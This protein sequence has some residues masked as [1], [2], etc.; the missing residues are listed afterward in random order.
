MGYY[1][2]IIRG[3]IESR[4]AIVNC[5]SDLGCLG[6][7]ERQ[8]DLVAYFVDSRD[9]NLIRQRL[10]L[11][12]DQLRDAGLDNRFSFDYSYLS[13]RDWNEP[14]KKRFV[15]IEIGDR[16]RII[17][18][19]GK[20]SPDRLDIIIDPGMAFGTGH[21]ETTLDCL[22]LIE[23]YSDSVSK[24]RFLDIGTGTGILAI[25]ASRFG[26]G[27]VLG[28]DIDPLAI[29]AA[30]RNVRLNRIRNIRIKEGI[31]RDIQGTFDMIAANL[32]SDVL[33]SISGEMARLLKR[34]GLIILSGMLEGQEIEVIGE[35]ERFG[36]RLIELIRNNRWVSV[37][38]R[39]ED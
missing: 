28:I 1:E 3:P 21:H 30:E 37:V 27:D 29:D 24:E 5:L 34:S 35:M 18:P 6:F 14:W 8:S 12:R 20:G 15:P 38:M 13:E 25:G 31:A 32:M 2:F 23:R 9:V 19:W 36:L 39:P 7:H 10:N 17:P 26:F 11:L 4:D 16:L 33:I 22:L